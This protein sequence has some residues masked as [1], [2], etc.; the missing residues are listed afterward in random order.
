MMQILTTDDL[1]RFKKELFAE[2]KKM[3]GLKEEPSTQN[4]YL[5]SIEVKKLFK[6]SATKLYE[7]RRNSKIPFIKVGGIYLYPY[8]ELINHFKTY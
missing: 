3:F 4:K 6:I 1:E 8:N 7:L 5:K 2:L